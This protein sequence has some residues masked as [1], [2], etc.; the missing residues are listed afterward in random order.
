MLNFFTKRKQNDPLS[1][2]KSTTHWLNELKV[3]D[4]YA[5]QQEVVQ[6]LADFNEQ[7]D[8]TSPA[9]LKVLLQ[10]DQGVQPMQAALCRQYLQNPRMSRMIESRLWN[11]IQSLSTALAQGYHAFIMGYVAQPNG[12][13]IA[14]QL[15]LITARAV[16]HTGIS[17][18]WQHF[19][20][21]PISRKTF[22][23][24]N[25]LYRFAE[26]EEFERSR[27]KLYDDP[28]F[29]RETSV[30]DEYLRVMM[31]N[32]LHPG[33][34]TPKQIELADQWLMRWTPLI[35][36]EREY[37]RDRHVFQVKLDDDRGARRIR[38]PAEDA[39]QRYWATAQ[40]DMRMG[41][42]L[43][44]LRRG[45][46]SAKAELSEDCR[47]PVCAEF[48]EYAM[49]Q[50][51]PTGPK[52]TQ[53]L[54]ERT[55]T[56]KM[57]EVVKNFNDFHQLIRHDN[58]KAM[59]RSD[60]GKDPG[61]SYDEM[62]DVRLYGFVTQR[63]QDRRHANREPD[64]PAKYESERWIA[65]NESESG[66]GASIAESR[67]DWVGLSKLFALRPERGAQ[68]LIGVVRRL[69]KLE[70]AQRY[71]GMEIICHMPFAVQMRLPG[72]ARTLTVDGIDP[73][74]AHLPTLA[75]F[76]PK[77][78]SNRDYDSILLPAGEYARSNN[79]QLE[80]QGK[81]YIIEL[82]GDREKGDG[83]VRSAFEVKAKKPANPR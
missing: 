69:S 60:P 40:L 56:M 24:L 32:A 57:I 80:L 16:Y 83:W 36:V 82:K 70:S 18:K 74:G 5:A 1:D 43:H 75:L 76:L 49:L 50:W 71:V 47:L 35:E 2:P 68:W 66:F 51:G 12:S 45:E 14:A 52:R 10:T 79:W 53:R 31:L 77:A 78:R 11:A 33:G 65:E 22:G 59:R 44:G 6:A 7:G 54:K 29:A 20:Y 73:V 38:R 48:L 34:L 67:E 9:R 63:T 8:F 15:P 61:V 28:D 4:A 23:A 41:E 26:F 58:F 27:L 46:I 81:V 17:A 13:K 19:R 55:H 42:A 62:L 3:R 64:E 21:E 37:V 25:N 72:E 39:M 30:A